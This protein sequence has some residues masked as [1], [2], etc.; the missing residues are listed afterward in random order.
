MSGDR[1][2]VRSAHTGEMGGAADDADDVGEVPP[3]EAMEEADPGDAASASRAGGL[4]SRG[5]GVP[6]PVTADDARSEAYG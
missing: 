1:L 2:V 6:A 4:L 3:D 5:L